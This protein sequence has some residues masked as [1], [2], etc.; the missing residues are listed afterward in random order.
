MKKIDWEKLYDDFIRL[1][2]EFGFSDKN[3]K[4]DFLPIIQHLTK[5]IN[6][7][8]E[9]PTKVIEGWI[10]ND[11]KEDLVKWK[12]FYFNTK[13]IGNKRVKLTIYPKKVIIEQNDD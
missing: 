6:E 3:W 1:S 13:S 2:E 5:R 10:W 11:W 9:Q 12:N 7:Q 8:N 4:Q